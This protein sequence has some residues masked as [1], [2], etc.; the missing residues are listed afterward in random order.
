MYDPLELATETA[1]IVCDESR[2]KYYRFRA[3]QFYGGIATAD[4][5]G[6]CLRCVFCWS[7][8]VV[9]EPR[10][11]GRFYTPQQV[12]D[13]LVS[14][15]R[16]NDFDQVRISGNE[17]TLGRD[18][19]VQVIAL[20]P[21]D[22]LFILETNGI[23]LGHDREYAAA[24]AQFPHVRVR[25]SLKGSTAEEF[26]RLTGAEP[27]AFELQLAALRNLV[28][29]GADVS[30]AVMGS[31]SEGRSLRALRDQLAKVSPLLADL[32]LEEVALYGDAERRLASAGLR[33]RGG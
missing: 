28:T 32:E 22:L 6:C 16:K 17:P 9:N 26:T 27:E 5:V 30:A 20:V 23:L 25:V 3:A 4:C 1:S 18:H 11:S 10:G 33:C 31:F 7:W 2:R 8:R 12:V 15:A 29:A 13:N 19:L 24:L 14:I 21:T